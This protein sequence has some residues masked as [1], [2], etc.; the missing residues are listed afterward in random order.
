MTHVKASKDKNENLKM[1]E[2][3]NAMMNGL[4]KNKDEW[5]TPEFLM[6]L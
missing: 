1:P 2:V 4:E 3:Q 5:L 6:K